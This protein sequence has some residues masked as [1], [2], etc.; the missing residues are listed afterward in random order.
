MSDFFTNILLNSI[1]ILGSIITLYFLSNSLLYLLIVIIAIYI[2]ISLILNKRICKK[3]NEN[4][5]TTTEFNSVLV[6]TIEMNTSIKN[7]NLTETF[8]KKI[9]DKLILMLKSNFKAEETLN[10]IEGLKNTIY[11]LGIFLVMT[12]GMYLVYKEKISILHLITFNSILYHLMNP[13]KEIIGLM[14]RIDFL[15][16]SINKLKEFIN[17][18]RE[19]K[20]KGLKTIENAEI[21]VENLTYSY[22]Q[23][24]NI[25]EN[26]NF[27]IKNQEKVL[28]KGK[29]GSGKSTLCRLICKD[30]SNYKGIIKLNNTSEKDY[31]LEAIKKHITY[32][33]QNERLFSGTILE[34]IYCN[35]EIEEKDFLNIARICKLEEIVEKRP[36]RYQTFINASIN[37][38]SG[39]EK[40]RITLA[41]ALLK[42]S[43]VII[44]DEA[45]SEV[46]IELEKEIIKN[47]K[48]HFQTTTI[49]YVSHK[50]VQS[51]FKKIIDVGVNNV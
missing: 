51:E 32:V 47:I 33:G 13:V 43:K 18:P 29:S 34:N 6:E 10:K 5:E 45:L 39:G 15:I 38:L 28:L 46:N 44:L 8:L 17:I 3:I 20:S 42:K 4:I 1:L 16:G 36:N 21:I 50:N 49:I 25:L 2:L 9:E 23:Y 37:N 40:Q 24:D 27:T 30:D 14:P 19:E 31:S 41:R 22:N 7:L 48:K 11:E 26:I 35:R 12:F